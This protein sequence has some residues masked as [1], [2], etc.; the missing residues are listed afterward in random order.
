MDFIAY[1]P[2]LPGAGEELEGHRFCQVPG[3]KGANQALAVARLGGTVGLV[4]ASAPIHG[5]TLC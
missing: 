2:K 3:G 4:A 5:V 1:G